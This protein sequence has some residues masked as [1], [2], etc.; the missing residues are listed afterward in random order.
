MYSHVSSDWWLT[1]FRSHSMD[2]FPHHDPFPRHVQFHEPLFDQSTFHHRSRTCS[3]DFPC[4]CSLDCKQLPWN[5]LCLQDWH[6]ESRTSTN[7]DP[8]WHHTHMVGPLQ[9][10]DSK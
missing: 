4:I 1:S 3:S 5:R 6:Q 9:W 10:L 2:W 8:C 7:A